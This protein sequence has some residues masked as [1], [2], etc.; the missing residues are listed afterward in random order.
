MNK[1]KIR[2]G[3]DR[4]YKLEPHV[5]EAGEVYEKMSANFIILSMLA[6]HTPP[7]TLVPTFQ[8]PLPTSMPTFETPSPLTLVPTLQIVSP[9]IDSILLSTS[10]IVS[11][12][13][14]VGLEIDYLDENLTELER[15]AI[16]WED[17]HIAY[18][19][20]MDFKDKIDK[21]EVSTLTSQVLWSEFNT[22][23]K[24]CGRINTKSTENC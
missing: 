24:N 9:L 23:R 12:S 15:L 3:H 14:T 1:K 19:E 6:S 18:Y 2:V 22:T 7:P 16:T 13:P 20:S 4:A 11:G 17:S 8:T 21:R 5:Q 10:E